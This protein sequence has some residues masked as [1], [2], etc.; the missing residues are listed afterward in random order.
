MVLVFM[1]MFMIHLKLIFVCYLF[2]EIGVMA[3][4]FPYAYPFIPAPFVKKSVLSALDYS[5]IFVEKQV[6]M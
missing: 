4:F 5:V 6:I 1:L 3:H 2:V